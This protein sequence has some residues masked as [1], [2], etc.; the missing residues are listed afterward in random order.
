MRLVCSCR[1]GELSAVALFLSLNLIV[2]PLHGLDGAGKGINLLVNASA[3]SLVLLE[4]RAESGVDI[5]SVLES[6]EG[7]L[8]CSLTAEGTADLIH[9]GEERVYFW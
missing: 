9:V 2:R 4:L 7:R 6:L 1:G 5:V 8:G 3:D